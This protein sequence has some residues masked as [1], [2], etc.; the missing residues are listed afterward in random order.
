MPSSLNLE[1]RSQFISGPLRLTLQLAYIEYYHINPKMPFASTFSQCR[2]ARRLQT[3]A[4]RYTLECL[5]MEPPWSR[6]TKFTRLMYFLE[7][8]VGQLL[9]M[10]SPIS[11]TTL[12]IVFLRGLRQGFS[13]HEE[14]CGSLLRPRWRAFGW[15]RWLA[16]RRE[17]DIKGTT[18]SVETR[19][20][21]GH[22]PPPYYASLLLPPHWRTFL[23]EI[24]RQFWQTCEQVRSNVTISPPPPQVERL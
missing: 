17:I 15:S 9:N 5:G 18:A 14:R 22:P 3:S 10:N 11:M 13:D 19:T 20:T 21:L 16:I 7:P 2:S 6:R 4:H 12:W 24:V 8:P 1:V 23:R